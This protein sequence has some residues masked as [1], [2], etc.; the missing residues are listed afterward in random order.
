[1]RRAWALLLV[2]VAVTVLGAGCG[3]TTTVAVRARPGGTGTVTVRV[4]LDA[5]A[6]AAI[7]G[8]AHTLDT[9][10][11]AAAGWTVTEPRT[12]GGTA[13]VVAS[14]PFA[15]PA[16]LPSLLA[17]VAVSDGRPLFRLRLTKSRSWW[18]N[19]TSIAG[20]VDLRCGVDCFGDAG[21]ARAT[22]SAVGVNPA[23]LERQYH[24][25][26]G[27][28]LRF[29][30]IVQ[31]PGS[32]T[33]TDAAGRSGSVLRWD[34]RLGEE[35]TVRAETSITD[36]AHVVDTAAALAAALVVFVAIAVVLGVRRRRRRSRRRH[37]H[38]R[39][40]GAVSAPR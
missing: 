31:L 33:R 15:E 39:R 12:A 26:P 1:M 2:A 18:S 19:H 13:T 14:H 37:A 27:Q 38:G 29:R 17:G 23:A 35:T 11:L 22:G 34:P 7:G 21:L 4:A 16:Q 32:V 9:A 36:H 24:E 20:S 40:R 10:G 28:A 8:L 30:L 25:T 3:V 5:A 6:N